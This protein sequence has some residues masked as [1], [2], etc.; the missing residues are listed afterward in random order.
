[1]AFAKPNAVES[2]D[3]WKA[4]AF[5]NFYLPTKNGTRVKLGA[6]ALKEGKVNDVALMAWLKDPQNIEALLDKLECDYKV[7]DADAPSTLDLS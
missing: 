2:N 1:M 6:I 4:A 3:S 7:V 5:I